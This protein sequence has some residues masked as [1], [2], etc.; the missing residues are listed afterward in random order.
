MDST[1]TPVLELLPA[2][3]ASSHPST[4]ESN[5][6]PSGS[7]ADTRDKQP[8]SYVEPLTWLVRSGDH[9]WSIA[10]THL[11][12]VLDTSPSLEQ[13]DRYWRLLVERAT[14]QLTSG[15]PDL[16]YPGEHINLPPLLDADIQP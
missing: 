14:P 7:E 3:E 15:D 2:T 11:E 1:P 10:G 8:G 4:P 9:L 12:I 6:R 5:D 16:I 13:H